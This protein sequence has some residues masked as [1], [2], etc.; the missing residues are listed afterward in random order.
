[1]NTSFEEKSVWVQLISLVVIFAGYFA[2]AGF[3]MTQGVPVLVAYVP[4]FM[5]S[6]VLLVIM[7]T[8]G[9]IVAVCFGKP[10]GRDERDRLIEWRAD[11]VS[12]HVLGGGVLIAITGMIFELDNVWIA[13][14]LFLL[15]FLS[16]VLKLAMQLVYYRRGV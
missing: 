10:E 12:S 16:E 11:S 8:A 6:V 13:H 15:M 1:M 3:M 14:F 4:L 5:A 2:V 7:L 9:H